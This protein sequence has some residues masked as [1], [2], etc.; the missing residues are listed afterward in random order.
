MMEELQD[1]IE[2]AQY[3]NAIA[4]LDDGPK[5]VTAWPRPSEEELDAWRKKKR[6]S[7]VTKYDMKDGSSTTVPFSMEW[8]V[9][10]EIGFFS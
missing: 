10:Q 8:V 6:V 5:P 7:S 1:A 4:T 3:V 9:Q 2:D